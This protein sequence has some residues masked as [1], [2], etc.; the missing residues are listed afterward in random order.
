MKITAFLGSPRK[1]GNSERLLT[2]AIKGTGLEVKIHRLNDMSLRP[3]Q[4]C[5]GCVKTGVCIIKDDMDPIYEDIRSS[6][7]L[8][9]ASPVFFMSVSAQSKILIDRCQAFWC[10]K[11]LLNK[12]I[13]AGTHG[14]KGL[15]ML[16]GG[17]EKDKGIKCAA[18]VATAFM[19]TVSVPEHQ[20]LMY[21]G[22]DEK[23]EIDKHKSALDEALEAGRALIE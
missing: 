10:E 20:T 18:S 9:L 7:R 21:M 22:V 5:G 12:D 6:D 17:M 13:A 16:V 8:I 19:R 23:G 14:R 15:V 11:Y 4:N 2:Q 1:D 3:C